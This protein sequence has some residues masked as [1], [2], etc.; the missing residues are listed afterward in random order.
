MKWLRTILKWRL[1]RAL[2]VWNLKSV[3][4]QGGIL[5]LIPIIAVI[6]SFLFAIYGNN[7]RGWIQYDIQRRFK[8]V[9]QYNDLLMLMVNAETGERGYLLTRKPEYLE[10]YQKAV[11]EIPQA[12][13]AVRQTIEEEPGEKP[14]LERLNSLNQIENLINQQLASLKVSQSYAT[15]NKNTDELSAH[16]QNG[17]NL[18]DQI[19]ANLSQM[20]SRDGELLSER[21]EDINT[22]RNR[23]Y[24]LLFVALLVGLIVRL[25]SFYLFDRGIVRRIERLKDY[26]AA[27]NK[28]ESTTYVGSKKSDAIGMLEEEIST[29]A[30]QR[31]KPDAS[32][33]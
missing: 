9:R 29:L 27:L 18:M 21:I 11:A 16:L 30:K 2:Q 28:G 3:R 10:P 25:V 19:R 1:I 26:V 23:D 14:R 15:E 7:S 32:P 8:L 12:I 33:N 22:I 24:I 13:S 31:A 20:E 17:K 6:V 4:A 5:S